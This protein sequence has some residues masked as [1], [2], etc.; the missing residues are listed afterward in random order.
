MSLECLTQALISH[1]TK[2]TYNAQLTGLIF[3]AEDFAKAAGLTRSQSL[4]EMQ[5]ARQ[6]IVTISKAFNL[7][8][9]DLVPSSFQ[10]SFPPSLPS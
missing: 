10:P 9:I 2:D 8:C 4:I 7:Q 1:Y 6:R 3:G 5:Y